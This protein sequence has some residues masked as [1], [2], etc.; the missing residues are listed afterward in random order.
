MYLSEVL[1]DVGGA[2]H[3]VLRRRLVKHLEVT[4]YEVYLT[5]LHDFN[6]HVQRN[7]NDHLETS[8]LGSWGILHSAERG[9]SPP[10][11]SFLAI[12][13]SFGQT[14]IPPFLA[15]FA[16]VQPTP[17]KN[18]KR[19][20]IVSRM[21]LKSLFDPIVYGENESFFWGKVGQDLTLKSV[22]LQNDDKCP[23]S[24]KAFINM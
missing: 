3:R 7:R 6:R 13:P 10:P 19:K 24:E 23:E 14:F 2:T 21:D 4:V 16:K 15:N 20:T 17:L 9:M 22:N 18:L 5:Q 11:F 12:P 1:V 8:N